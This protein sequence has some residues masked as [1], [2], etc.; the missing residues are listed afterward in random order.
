[1][2]TTVEA[3]QQ[4]L[5]L[6]D[7][8]IKDAVAIGIGVDKEIW[9]LGDD[10][11]TIDMGHA[12]RGDEVFILREDRNLV[13]LAGAGRI[14]EHH[15]AVAFRTASLLAAIVDAFGD[16]HPTTFVE[17]DVGRIGDLRGSR[18]DR[19]LET[20]GHREEFS[21]YERRPSIV[22]DRL[23][24]LRTGRE[25]RELDVGTAGLAATDGATVVDAD[26]SSEGL[27]RTR[28]IKGN[29][30][31]GVRA[32]AAGVFLASNLER[33]AVVV[34]ADPGGTKRLDFL[35]LEFR[36]VNHRAVDQDNL[37]INPICPIAGI[38]V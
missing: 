14:F 35:P 24:F 26:L 15:D 4:Y 33:L 25:D 10:D 30:G 7:L 6:V 20:F 27:R 28:Q 11:L 12:Q 8:G 38:A 1:M 13:G 17:I 23:I 21:W 18:P 5:A 19:H 2:I 31:T 29:K 16:I 32:D 9:R 37:R 36:Q 34:L 22:I 3:G